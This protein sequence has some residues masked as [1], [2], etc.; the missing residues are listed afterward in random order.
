MQATGS[1]HV[2]C[3]STSLLCWH[4]QQQPVCRGSS[5]RRLDS[6]RV[7][8]SSSSPGFH[9]SSEAV[10]GQLQRMVQGVEAYRWMRGYSM[11]TEIAR[12]QAFPHSDRAEVRRFQHASMS[13]FNCSEQLGLASQH[14]PSKQCLQLHTVMHVS[15]LHSDP[16]YP[17][18]IRNSRDG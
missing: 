16:L 10:A 12:V 18:Y 15:K 1:S 11:N 13:V 7:H 3:N 8:S 5:R 17:T 2:S 6:S 4:S 14:A 9:M